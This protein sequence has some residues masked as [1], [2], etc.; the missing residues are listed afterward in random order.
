MA[1]LG[2]NVAQIGFSVAQMV[3]RWLAVRQARVRISARRP[4]EVP[5]TEPAS[6]KIWMNV[7]IV[8]RKRNVQKELRKTTTKNPENSV[9]VHNDLLKQLI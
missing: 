3:L 1:Q 9:N 5:P 2:C 7:C 4:M 8:K 6:M